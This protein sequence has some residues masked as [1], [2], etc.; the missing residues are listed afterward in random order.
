MEVKATR[1]EG[2]DREYEF[3]VPGKEVREK[4]DEALEGIRSTIQLRGFRAG[5]APMSIIKR[6]FA[7]AALEDSINDR[8]KAEVDSIL[9]SNDETPFG[10]PKIDV[11]DPEGDEGDYRVKVAYECA[12]A[13]PDIDFGSVVVKR[14]VVSVDEGV[15]AAAVEADA[16]VHTPFGDP[17]EGRACRSGDEIVVSV[18]ARVDGEEVPGT[19]ADGLEFVVRDDEDH[20]RAESI[21][22][23]YG[24]GP[25]QASRQDIDQ[26][27]ILGQALGMKAGDIA[28][29]EFDVPDDPQFEHAAGRRASGEFTVLEVHPAQRLEPEAFGEYLGIGLG[30]HKERLA[31]RLGNLYEQYAREL[32]VHDM[33]SQIDQQLEFEVPRSIVDLDYANLRNE[34]ADRDAEREPLPGSPEE[35][36]L[37]ADPEA[38]SA[39]DDPAE[40]GT[41]EASGG[42][43]EE[44]EK[45]GEAEEDGKLSEAEEE[46]LRA[47]ATRRLRRTL[48][49]SYIQREHGLEV[50]DEDLRRFTFRTLGVG[51]GFLAIERFRTDR[52]YANQF[53]HRAIVE[54]VN[55]FMLRLVTVEDEPCSSRDLAERWDRLRNID[56]FERFGYADDA[57]ESDG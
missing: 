46:K 30:A 12:P 14:P 47:L 15:L 20:E 38:E 1:R 34:K 8:V 36:T 53:R 5:K 31:K 49:Y 37:P 41:G 56:V 23:E 29:F 13:I 10:R 2:L 39:P 48:L 16:F 43:A 42:A 28:E 55:D 9:K 21:G 6:R 24:L 26:F 11:S 45:Q 18:V 22:V 27:D 57:S 50:T 33:N 17:E 4:Q 35:E 32:M 40:A 54:K 44:H 19:Q 25:Y 51:D 3:V 7:D 52:E